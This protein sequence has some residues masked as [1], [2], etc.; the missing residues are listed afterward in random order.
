MSACSPNSGEGGRYSSVKSPAVAT[1]STA[2]CMRV[3]TSKNR[4]MRPPNFSLTLKSD[5]SASGSSASGMDHFQTHI[6]GL[7]SL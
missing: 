7:V 4:N 3:T 5:M 1:E 6:S 2:P